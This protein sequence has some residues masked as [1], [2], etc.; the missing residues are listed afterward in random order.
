MPRPVALMEAIRTTRAS[1]RKPISG[2]AWPEVRAPG[3]VKAVPEDRFVRHGTAAEMR[4]DSVDPGYLTPAD[5]FFVRNHTATPLIDVASW[6][7]TIA[8]P[9]VA[10]PC[11][12]SYEDLIALASV[13]VVRS[14]ECAGNGRSFFGRGGRRAPEGHRW[15]LGGIGVA[16][17]T[18]AP[19]SALLDRAGIFETAV[20]VMPVGLDVLRV[21]RPMP[22]A[23]A[24]EPDTLV[25]IAMNGEPLTRDHGFPARVIVPGWA[26]ISS[27]KWVG[28]I[29]VSDTPMS[30]P[31]T[32]NAYILRGSA[33]ETPEHP[34][35]V[36]VQELGVKS[37]VELPW[38]AHL[39]PGLRVVRGRAWSG[40]GR[41]AFV[42]V[43]LDGGRAWRFAGLDQP[44]EPRA[45]VRWSLPWDARPGSYRIGVRATDE[46]GT[47]QPLDVVW[48][49]LGYCYDGV[50]LHPVI[51]G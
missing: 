38:P 40:R 50:V 25:A 22:V 39:A 35:G 24:L 48:N 3:I 4:W 42:E 10:R 2:R 15:Q 29:E 13:R 5:R 34:E 14:I 33:Y 20:D 6:R 17:W 36:V 19:L 51:V 18:G 31:W 9:G 45:W 7:L 49:E 46:F 21:R 43:S 44:N 11:T 12:F 32:T 26:G 16:E 37:A 23:K 28:R 41:I 27:I 8:G 30:S 47:T 1:E